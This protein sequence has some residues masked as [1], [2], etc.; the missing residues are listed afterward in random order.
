MLEQDRNSPI[1]TPLY[2]IPSEVMNEIAKAMNFWDKFS[3]DKNQTL[4][5][6]VLSDLTF[7]YAT[8]KTFASSPGD[9]NPIDLSKVKNG[10]DAFK[11]YLQS[12]DKSS[13]R[14]EER[15]LISDLIS[16]FEIAI[17]SVVKDL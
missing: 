5:S 6:R 13:S 10:I 14:P 1:E 8:T 15:K 3:S 4:V 2:R 12:K 9:V 16:T 11:N 17:E 7:P